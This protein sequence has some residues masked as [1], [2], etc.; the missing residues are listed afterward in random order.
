MRK[1]LKVIFISIFVLSIVFYSHSKVLAQDTTTNDTTTTISPTP[2]FR[3]GQELRKDVKDFRQTIKQ[4]VKSR[5]NATNSSTFKQKACE[6]HIKVIKIRQSN[7]AKKSLAMQKRLDNISTLV[8]KYYTEKLIPQGKIVSNYDVLV[9]NINTNKTAL[10]PLIDKV[11]ADSTGLS[12]DKDQQRTQFQTFKTDWQALLKGFGVYRQS[13]IDLLKA[14]KGVIGE[15]TGSATSSATPE[16][17][18]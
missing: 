2:T 4:D 11:K 8:Q 3:P 1:L 18:Q 12:C 17:T 5:T 13:V 15:K 9:S 10:I 16:V 14:V 6:E 7:I